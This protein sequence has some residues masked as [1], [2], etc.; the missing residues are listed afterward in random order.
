MLF[1]SVGKDIIPPGFANYDT[2]ASGWLHEV[3]NSRSQLLKVGC[4][5]YDI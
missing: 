5:I 2:S 3:L 4:A 1:K